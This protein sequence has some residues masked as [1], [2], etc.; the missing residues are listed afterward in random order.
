[1]KNLFFYFACIFLTIN[2]YAQDEK[3][4]ERLS[5]SKQDQIMLDISHPLL[6]G[7]PTI[8]ETS[9]KSTSFNLNLLKDIPIGKGNCGFATG[10]VFSWD[11]HQ[12]NL[13]IKT[14]ETTGS[15]IYSI[16]HDS[17]DYKSNKLKILFID[18]PLELRIRTNKNSQ[19][20]YFRFYAGIKAGYLIK[21][22]TQLKTEES[23][24][25]FYAIPELNKFRYGITLRLGFSHWNIFSY[26]QLSSLFNFNE[27][28][29]AEITISNPLSE[30]NNMVPCSIGIS[31]NF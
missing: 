16:L 29:L 24:Q 1:M 11:E 3:K 19:G 2:L 27:E 23:K 31:L 18:I 6:L 4:E 12:N 14:N 20:N 25:R 7:N 30:I 5:P 8:I 26:Y 13:N 10:I 17:S 21:S 9:L 15:G 28:E 22:F